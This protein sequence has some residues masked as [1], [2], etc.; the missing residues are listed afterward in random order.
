MDAVDNPTGA[1]ADGSGCQVAT[2]VN[3]LTEDKPTVLKASTASGTETSAITAAV[4]D[5]SV[6]LSKAFDGLDKV[7]AEAYGDQKNVA[8][9]VAAGVAAEAR[10]LLGIFSHPHT[11]SVKA[12]PARPDGTICFPELD[13]PDFAVPGLGDKAPIAVCISGGGFRA[14]TLGLG[15]LRGLQHL[16]LLNRVRYLSVI[17]GASWLGAALSF[18]HKADVSTFLG[19][20]LPP[21]ECNLTALAKD[22]T[23]D[24]TL[25]W[26][27]CISHGGASWQVIGS[28]PAGRT[29]L[30]RTEVGDKGKSYARA[31]ADAMPLFTFVPEVALSPLEHFQERLRAPLLLLS[32]DAADNADYVSAFDTDDLLQHDHLR[33]FLRH[34]DDVEA[35]RQWT[36]A[37]AEAFLRPFGLGEVDKSTVRVPGTKIAEK[38]TER[39]SKVGRGNNI[40]DANVKDLPFLIIGQALLLPRADARFYPFEWTALYGGCPVAYNDIHPKLGAGWTE[41]LGLNAQLVRKDTVADSGPSTAAVKAE[42]R[43]TGPASL[44]EAMG[45]SSAYLSLVI[46]EKRPHLLNVLKD[47]LGFQSAQYFNMQDWSTSEVL[48]SDGGGY[49]L[50]GIYP[51]LRRQLPNIILFNCNGVPLLDNLKSFCSDKDLPGLFGCLDDPEANRQRQVFKPEGFQRLFEALRKKQAVGEAPVHADYY[52]VLDN[53]HLGIKGGWTVRVMWVLNERMAKWEAKLP[54]ATRKKILAPKMQGLLPH[55]STLTSFPYVELLSMDYSPEL[56]SLLANHAA[57]M[58]VSNKEL[59]TDMLRVT[60]PPPAEAAVV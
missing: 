46:G 22:P 8:S 34:K 30:L 42:V 49:D 1:A 38:V 32:V 41:T 57:W 55:E 40:Y 11:T 21:E 26:G 27:R 50:Y 43:P 29:L 25:V 52:E 12:W 3:P 7:P 51:L 48:L 20:Y 4:H 54:E 59:V 44:G 6:G 37:M 18:Q 14:T 58:L 2:A 19:P 35:A 60:A 56:V 36:R 13:D 17:S 53:R 16:G 28:R 31:V 33:T 24:M 23:Q 10:S 9:T 5:A 39:A 47:A 45:I 15:W